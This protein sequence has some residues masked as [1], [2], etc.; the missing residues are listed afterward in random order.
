M[1]FYNILFYTFETFTQL[2]YCDLQ[3]SIQHR[4]D[5]GTEIRQEYF[6]IENLN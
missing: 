1:F 6:I 3:N 2:I 4:T 5:C